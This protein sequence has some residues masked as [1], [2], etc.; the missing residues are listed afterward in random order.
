MSRILVTGASGFLGRHIVRLALQEN[1]FVTACDVNPAVAAECQGLK[2]FLFV[3]HDLH[4]PLESP[5]KTFDLPD[6][7]IHLAWE[8]TNDYKNPSH[9]E[10]TLPEN[11]QFLETLIKSG[12]HNINV[13]GTSYEY[14]M[15]EG[16]LSENMPAEPIVPYAVAKDELRKYLDNLTGKYGFTMK[17]IRLFYPYGPGQRKQSVFEQLKTALDNNE[18]VFN[19]SEGT[20][21][22]DFIPVESASGHILR[23]SLQ[24]SIT[25]IINCGT[26]KGTRLID[27]VNSIIKESGKQITLNRGGY[28]PR[29]FEPNAFWADTRKM[30]L[31]LDAYDHMR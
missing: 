22:L 2:N 21:F 7:L 15:K 12:V 8:N 20:Q 29:D 25:G 11:K 28:P 18:K 9:L 26:G 6:T 16:K 4:K 30:K 17:W 5:A 14:G 31:A 19:M 23:I 24:K 27:R 13:V 1:L 3:N 10:K